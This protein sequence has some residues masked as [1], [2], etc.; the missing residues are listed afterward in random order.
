M[1]NMTKLLGIF[2]V[3]LSLLSLSGCSTT[4]ASDDFGPKH[5]LVIQVSSSDPLTQKI[6]LNNAV[7][8]QKGLG[9][10]NIAVEIV[11]YGP[12]LSI[13]TAKSKNAKRVASLAVQGI[14]FSAC[15]N[16][17]KKITKKKGKAPK[18]VNGVKVVPG[19]VGRI[20]ALQE[21]GYSYI[22]P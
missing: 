14:R 17:I 21:K 6:A 15:G 19:G 10:D 12:G 3:M 7:N 8:I 5:K 2:A 4:G 11:A 20:I 13:L 9:I 18:L 16:T 22:R 1:K